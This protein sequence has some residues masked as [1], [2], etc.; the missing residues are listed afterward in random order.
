VATTPVGAVYA[1]VFL[2]ENAG[3]AKLYGLEAEVL[4]KPTANDLFTADIQW[5]HARYKS[6][7]YFAYS[8][9]GA[10]PAAGCTVAPTSRIAATTGAAI[11]SVDCS[12]RPL[13]NA[14]EWT[15]NLAYEHK[16]ELKG[17]ATVTLGADTRIQSASYVS[18]DYLPN[19]RQSAF[20]TSN[21]RL[22]FETAGG[23]FSLSA[24]VNNIENTNIFAASF[25]SPVKNGV[26]YNQLR[27]P[28][29]YGLRGSVRF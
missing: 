26:L 22:Q 5:L 7:G 11:F 12:G 17:G 29:T 25:Q 23:R 14:P 10:T 28:R 20:T 16:F 18:I 19:G 8:S 21:A 6:F 9:S 27:P 24:F 13:V 3:S 2:T 4:F 15:L 1:P